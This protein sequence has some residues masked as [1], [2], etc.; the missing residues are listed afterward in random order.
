MQLDIH[1]DINFSEKELKHLTQDK[2]T[3]QK[4]QKSRE[5]QEKTEDPEDVD[6]SGILHLAD[7]ILDTKK[8][9]NTKNKDS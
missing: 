5:N 4:N 9:E 2:K 6:L 3:C 8:D 1:I 7:Q